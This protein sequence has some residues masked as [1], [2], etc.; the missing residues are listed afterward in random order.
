MTSHCICCTPFSLRHLAEPSRHLCS[1]HL[2]G[3]DSLAATPAH[4]LEAGLSQEP[5][6][7]AWRR[8]AALLVRDGELACWRAFSWQWLESRDVVQ[9]V[10]DMLSSRH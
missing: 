10:A 5:A 8:A 6:S 1:R 4:E 7:S 9:Q 2:R 3:D